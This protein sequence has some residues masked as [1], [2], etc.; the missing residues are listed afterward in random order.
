MRIPIIINEREHIVTEVLFCL[1][2]QLFDDAKS[3]FLRDMTDATKKDWILYC[4]L[5]LEIVFLKNLFFF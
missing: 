4:R 3:M 1:G 2:Y 5:A